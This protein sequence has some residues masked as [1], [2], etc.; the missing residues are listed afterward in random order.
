MKIVTVPSKSSQ[1]AGYLKKEI[2]SGRLAPGNRLA[3]VR[4]LA[5][6]FSVSKKVIEM[7]FDALA[8]DK[9]LCRKD[10]SGIFVAD[11][12]RTKPKTVALFMVPEGHI[13]EKQTNLIITEFQKNGYMTIVISPSE[14]TSRRRS[15]IDELL[16]RQVDFIVVDGHGDFPFS[17]LEAKAD[18]LPRLAF[19]NRFESSTEFDALYVLSDFAAGADMACRRLLDDGRKRVLY[20]SSDPANFINEPYYPICN[21]SLMLETCGRVLREGGAEMRTFFR[22]KDNREAIKEILRS[23]K[24]PDGVFASMDFQ[25]KEIMGYCAELGL[26]VPEDVA[27]VGYYNTPWAELIA[28]SLTSVS[29]QEDVIATTLAGKL[30]SAGANKGG[31]RIIIKPKLVVRQSC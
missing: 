14:I 8:V 11:W 22:N 1:V 29:I 28:P 6:K 27:V 26:R 31:E 25:A 20:V 15:L 3:T 13:Y 12:N 10:R 19:I 24:R 17:A 5:G 18:K 16:E 30:L 2:L 23:K 9:L 7:A 4:E 21:H